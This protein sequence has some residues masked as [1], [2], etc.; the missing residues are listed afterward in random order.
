MR[1][2]RRGLIFGLVSLAV[3][4]GPVLA[5][6]HNA[7]VLVTESTGT[8][9]DMSGLS[10]PV[11]TVFLESRDLIL[12]TGLD[13]RI[14]TAAGDLPHMLVDDKVMFATTVTANASDPLQFTVGET[15]LTDF[16]IIAGE[17]GYVGVPSDAAMDVGNNFEIEADGY[18]QTTAASSKDQNIAFKPYA[19]RVYSRWTGAIG[20]VLGH[21]TGWTSPTGFVDG[22]GTWNNEVNAFDDNTATFADETVGATSWG[23]FLEL[24]HAA[25]LTDGMRFWV[26]V[27]HVDVNQIDVDMFYN[28]QWN[29]VWEGIF[30]A[31]QWQHVGSELTLNIA[32]VTSIRIRLYNANAGPQVAQ[33]NE[34]VYGSR[35]AEIAWLAGPSF[36]NGEHVI[37][38]SA[39]AVNF[40]LDVDGTSVSVALAGASAPATTSDWYIG[41]GNVTPYL[42]DYQHTVG[43]VLIAAYDPVSY[44]IGTNLDDSV[45]PDQDGV[46]VW[47]ENPTG[48]S[49]S[50]SGLVP[51]AT[52]DADAE[53]QLTPEAV[54]IVQP[55]AN[56]FPATD[57]TGRG[58]A[59]FPFID[60]VAELADTSGE[61]LRLWLSML[62]TII[63]LAGG[64]LWTK[65][66]WISGIGGTMGIGAGIAMGVFPEWFLIVVIFYVL[67]VVSLDKAKTI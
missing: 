60:E 3:L 17:D 59:V 66:L 21:I 20:E 37:T 25:L 57:E 38:A 49:V 18:F 10:V 64:Y 15:A 46:F 47:G 35:Q 61:M 2:F 55:V 5:Q 11:D 30:T 62:I 51:V 44:I 32:T 56:L 14:T 67:G 1:R 36:A 48:V 33:I 12:S 34:V 29:D 8:A 28:A 45:F 53:V 43:G 7:T 26:T 4:A 31:G 16:H 24:T 40:T 63:L 39:D 42:N 27:G 50:M 22:G 52:Y 54:G 9:Q 19:L 23:N 58:W 13:T 65:S 41:T 6:T